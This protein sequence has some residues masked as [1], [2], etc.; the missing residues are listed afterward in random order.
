MASSFGAGVAIVPFAWAVSV[1]GAAK[2]NNIT[3]YIANDIFVNG[4][5]ALSFFDGV[6]GDSGVDV[7]L[8]GRTN[9]SGTRI[10]AL[11]DVGFDPQQPI[12]QYSIGGTLGTPPTSGSWVS[13]GNNGYASGGN[14]V[15]ALNV[16]GSGNAVGYVGM[17]DA[18]SLKG[19][20]IPI[21]YEGVSPFVG[22]AWFGNSTPWNLAGIEN[23]SYTFWS[24]EH[25]YESTKVG[26]TSFINANFGPDLINALEYEITHP[27]AGTVQ[28]A[29]LIKNMN[30]HRNAD[31][32]DVLAGN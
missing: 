7:Y 23:G 14:V 24:Y 5:E 1:D 32:A 17:A 2:I 31:G 4:T 6:A 10:S 8:T 16:A 29:D 28:S 15:K 3:P 21:N 20:A 26:S 22:S 18:A 11:V 30:V 12:I 27:A 13:V 25:L 9:D 19:G